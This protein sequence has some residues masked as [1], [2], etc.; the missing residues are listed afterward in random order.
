MPEE[1][2]SSP[3]PF[4]RPAGRSVDPASPD[5]LDS[6]LAEAAALA[7]DV[8]SELCESDHEQ[9]HETVNVPLD[10]L[11]RD[12]AADVDAR[13]EDLDALVGQAVNEVGSRD[14]S[15]TAQSSRTASQV[16]AF[17]DEF[18]R[19]EEPSAP[20]APPASGQPAGKANP[21]G[22]DPHAARKASPVPAAPPAHSPPSAVPSFM[23][24]FT[25]PDKSIAKPAP[26]ARAT[27][28]PPGAQ[29]AAAPQPTRP[30]PPNGARP[31]PQH[32]P[33][34]STATAVLDEPVTEPNQ[35]EPV[36]EPMT[37]SLS[38]GPPDSP[39]MATCW[40]AG[41][42]MADLLEMLDR[43]LRGVGQRVRSVVAFMSVAL[44]VAA[45]IVFVLTL[46]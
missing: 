17:M 2:Q 15:P 36:D 40:R 27:A 4:G 10:S 21:P 7:A 41:S 35:E 28:T 16:P 39:I 37:E 44:L 18:T 20:A 12:T 14:G 38:G 8:S 30:N 34:P 29:P 13:L 22:T 31:Q 24:E 23:D 43:P 9:H 46:L 45:F 42:R 6:L 1:P 11:D 19:P 25:R 5:E 3:P 32:P 33:A 26:A